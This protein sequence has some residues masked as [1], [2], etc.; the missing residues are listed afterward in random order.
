MKQIVDRNSTMNYHRQITI[1]L[2][3]SRIAMDH[4]IKNPTYSFV[5]PIYND[6]YLVESFC[7]A[8][9]DEMEG[10]SDVSDITEDVEVIFVNDGSSDES[11]QQLQTSAVRYGFVK[12]I[13]LSRN[14]GQHLAVS[15][16]YR[17]ASGTY[18]GM[19]NVDMQDPP[20]RYLC[21]S[22]RLNPGPV[23]L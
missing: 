4:L 14:F 21:C 6:G 2:K 7:E 3:A 5:V 10:L 19:M 15:C 17:L 16:G 9:N 8:I 20:I 18:V 13:E 1:I 12:V 23:I 22:K 11:Q